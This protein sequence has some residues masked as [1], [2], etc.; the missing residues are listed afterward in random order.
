M[1]PAIYNIDDSFQTKDKILNQLKEFQ[2]V[3]N[4]DVRMN[5][6]ECYD[7]SVFVTLLENSDFWKSLPLTHKFYIFIPIKKYLSDPYSGVDISRY[8][9]KKEGKNFDNDKIIILL[10]DDRFYLGGLLLKIP[11]YIS[12]KVEGHTYGK[13]FIME[14]DL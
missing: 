6:K 13:F 7:I 9:M 12:S 8:S 1:D 4:D 10:K 2:D 3:M 14:S 11:W 5:T